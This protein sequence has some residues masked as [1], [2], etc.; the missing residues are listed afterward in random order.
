MLFVL[1]DVDTTQSK[2]V[3]MLV[4]RGAEVVMAVRS[5]TKGEEAR[6]TILHDDPGAQISVQ[7]CDLS[8]FESMRS[9]IDELHREGL[10][11]DIVVFNA[12]VWCAE[13]IAS[14][15]GLDMTL[16]VRLCLPPTRHK[17]Y[18]PPDNQPGFDRSM[19]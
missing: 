19:C 11:F 8:C 6:D 13:W 17:T 5:I 3:S 9:F 7:A 16:Q 1:R 10:T 12:G 2:P 18:R 14:A 4:S 15:D